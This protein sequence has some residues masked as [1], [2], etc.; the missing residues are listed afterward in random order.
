MLG[1]LQL[2]PTGKFL[3]LFEGG[4]HRLGECPDLRQVLGTRMCV[5][6]VLDDTERI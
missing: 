1:S 2:H 4:E 5:A 6:T 3:G